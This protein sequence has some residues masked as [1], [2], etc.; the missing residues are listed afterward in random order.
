MKLLSNLNLA[1]LTVLISLAATPAR[2][3]AWYD[4]YSNTIYQN[5]NIMSPQTRRQMR[6]A[7]GR[8]RAGGA[9]QINAGG[10]AWA[11]SAPQAPLSPSASPQRVE[12]L[13]E[14]IPLA[15]FKPVEEERKNALDSVVA[16]M[17]AGPGRDKMRA[18]IEQLSVTV[19]NAAGPYKNNLA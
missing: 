18:M 10:N 15:G 4:N 5:Y 14:S 8:A 3:Q 17:P 19:E 1:A 13:A 9:G 7:T 6:E 16:G 2:A 11:P 12:S